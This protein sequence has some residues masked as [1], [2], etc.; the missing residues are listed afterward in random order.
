MVVGRRCFGGAACRVLP[1]GL[2]QQAVGLAGLLGE[3]AD[4]LL[5]VVPR[6]VD[7]GPLA[8]APVSSPGLCVQP[9]SATQA[10]HCAKVT[11]N[12]PTAK[13]CAKVTLRCGPSSG[14]R[15]FSLA[16]T[17]HELAGRH[18]DHLRAGCAVAEDAARARWVSGGLGLG[19]VLH[20]QS[21]VR[22][23]N[24]IKA[25]TVRTTALHRDP[26]LTI[27]VAGAQTMARAAS[28]GSATPAGDG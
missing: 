20:T 26:R 13:G 23:T 19:A 10:S 21:D 18:H 28:N 2:G 3:P 15:P 1:F 14:L 22:T 8:A 17:H 25:I 24:E 16:A 5:G 6:H 4:E 9:S 12:L 27:M 11:S 7:D